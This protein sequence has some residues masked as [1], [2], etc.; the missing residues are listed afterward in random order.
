ME[1]IQN[2]Q[3]QHLKTRTIDNKLQHSFVQEKFKEKE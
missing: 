3:Y 2:K 1:K